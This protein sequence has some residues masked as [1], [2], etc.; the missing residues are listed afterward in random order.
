MKSKIS[1][2]IYVFL[3]LFALS[4]QSSFA[5]DRKAL[6]ERHNIVLNQV[7]ESSPSQVGNGEFAFSAD[8]TGLQT[9]IPFNTMSHWAWHSFPKPKGMNPERDFKGFEFEIDGRKVPLC[10][11]E[12][13]LRNVS[14]SYREA[15]PKVQM[16]KEQQA[17]ANWLAGNPH[18]INLGRIGFE[19]KKSDDSFAKI[20]DVKDAKQTTFLYRGVLESSFSI[21]GTPVDVITFCAQDSDTVYVK[22]KSELL[23]NGRLKV[24][25]AF[26]YADR[27][28]Y[29]N[30]IGD[31]KNVDA[32][33]TSHSL[34]KNSASI[35]R[36]VD[37]LVYGVN[38]DFSQSAK[39][40]P[41]NE[42]HKFILS[43]DSNE[44][45]FSAE[46]FKGKSHKNK[47]GKTFEQALFDCETAWC[48]YWH[49]G[50]AID[51]S[52]CSDV[53]AKEL[54]RRAVLS[55]YLM[56]VQEA[57]AYP[58]QESGLVN[59]G[60]YGRFHFEMIWWHA[61]HF[62]YWGRL[63]LAKQQLEIYAKYLSSA[64]DVAKKQ[65]YTGA[66][67]YKCTADIPREWPHM[68]HAS[69]IWQQPHPIYFAEQ[70]YRINPSKDVLNKWKDVVFET[71]EFMAS[72]P[73]KDKNG[74][75]NLEAPLTI[76]S[77]NTDVLKTRNPT[78]E[79][80]YWRYGLQTA[81]KWQARLGV[82]ENKK[83]RDV[84]KNLAPL[85][86]ENGVYVT[87]EGVE[88]MWNKLNFEHPALIG[89]YGMIPNIGIDKKVFKKTYASV[90]KH[91]QFDK[92]WGWD[93]PM[94]AMAASRIG[95]RE[96]AI[97]ALVH[98][99]KNFQFD[100]HGLATGGPFPYMPSNG[101][102]LTALAMLA[103]G[104]DDADEDAF[105]AI[106]LGFPKNS[107]WKVK[108]EGFN[109]RQ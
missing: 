94:L 15:F 71:A 105:D 75:F 68:I 107:K 35:K 39:F 90:L 93:F 89:A 30:F 1:I 73:V 41:A 7:R 92:I 2:F 83:W 16:S 11:D 67:W 33:K 42:P 86:I 57:G 3:S 18:A 96:G 44:L 23:K 97:N 36:K 58:P 82:S 5:I 14:K 91:W 32:H 101:G 50:A 95:D 22:V 6:V 48:D 17:M 70:E 12:Q 37:D 76:V 100:E 85:P 78:F 8:I 45:E 106:H 88:D 84:L 59:N 25:F 104:W 13:S 103:G 64:K 80:A 40:A 87:F 24:F 79:L 69:L 108:A 77:E 43:S 26:P 20:T 31:W 61:V 54:E 72:L 52:Q 29:T 38:V 62:G 98:S 56:K 10:T 47:A 27:K 102:F 99:S 9:F 53:R 74:K 81:L 21:E 65:G 109:K 63:D 66:R 49:S 55:Q 46:F 60:W 4:S 19:I 51:F 34:G 28:S